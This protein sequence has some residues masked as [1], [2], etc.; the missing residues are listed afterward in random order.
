[1][2]F[3]FFPALAL[4]AALALSFPACAD[5]QRLSEGLLT[6]VHDASDAPLA[7]ETIDILKEALAEYTTRLPAGGDPITVYL[8][9]TMQ[10]FKSRAG[11]YGQARVGGVA[12]ADK[13]VII[14]KTPALLPPSAQFRGIIR[15]ELIHVLLARN[16]EAAYVPRWFDEGIAMILSK[17]IRWESSLEVARMYVQRRLIPYIELN[18]AF[19]PIGD[20]STFGGAYAQA[21]SMTRWLK[22]RMGEDR[23]WQLVQS[24][25]AMSFEDAIRLHAHLTPAGLDDGWRASLWKVAL[26][27]SLVSGFSAFQ[28]MA[29]LAVVAYVYKWRRGQRI[30]RQWQEE[31]N[32]EPPAF[33]WESAEEEPYSWEEEEDDDERKW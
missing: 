4:L 12:K 15:H 10:E 2:I 1:M 5:E 16:T 32:G 20:E 22:N 31:D 24:L 6:I 21:L 7:R 18:F 19:A 8:C 11:A 14:A 28:L 29:I 30:L 9:R 23:F 3:R 26:V 13:G 27:A 33:E 17:E 25:R